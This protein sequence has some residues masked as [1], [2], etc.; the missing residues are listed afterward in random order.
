MDNKTP[1]LLYYPTEITSQKATPFIYRPRSNFIGDHKSMSLSAS[2]DRLGLGPKERTNN[3]AQ[4]LAIA[5]TLTPRKHVVNF[6]A[7]IDDL[8]A[9]ALPAHQRTRFARKIAFGED[10]VRD[11]S[12]A[13]TLK[14]RQIKTNTLGSGILMPGVHVFIVNPNSQ[15]GVRCTHIHISSLYGQGEKVV[16]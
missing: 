5:N 3:E 15:G 1:Q 9:R 13:L 10:V 7:F 14:V 8:P 4:G 6:S 16:T 11:V 2:A 12:Q